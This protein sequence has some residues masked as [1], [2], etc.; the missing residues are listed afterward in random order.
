M[1]IGKIWVQGYSQLRVISMVNLIVVENQNTT[2][3]WVGIS[4]QYLDFPSLVYTQKGKHIHTTNLCEN[5]WN[6][7]LIMEPSTMLLRVK[8]ER[9]EN[10][11]LHKKHFLWIRLLL[12]H[13]QPMCLFDVL[14]SLCTSSLNINMS[15]SG[16]SSAIQFKNIAQSHLLCSNALLETSL[17][18]KWS[19][20]RVQHKV[21][22]DA[23][24]LWQECNCSWILSKYIVWF[25]L[26]N[27]HINEWLVVVS[28]HLIVRHGDQMQHQMHDDAVGFCRPESFWYWE[29]SIFLQYYSLVH[30]A[31]QECGTSG[32]TI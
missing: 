4:Q 6:L 29:V 23:L 17:C 10:H 32:S 25:W 1:Q 7:S 2:Q 20:R 11:L 28:G 16:T 26:S 3:V 21:V 24:T 18:V 22:I 15:G 27:A 9:M 19:C 8:I 13:D 30:S 5:S 12:C 31:M 14:S